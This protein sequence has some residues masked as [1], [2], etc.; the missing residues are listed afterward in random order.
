MDLLIE[1]S[2]LYLT[3]AGADVMHACPAD[4]LNAD[5]L[6]GLSPP[7]VFVIGKIL[8]EAQVTV[9]FFDRL[10]HRKQEQQ[11]AR[12]KV[13][14]GLIV[15]H[16][17]T[18]STMALRRSGCIGSDNQT[19]NQ[20]AIEDNTD[21]SRIEPA[22]ASC[23]FTV[24]SHPARMAVD[25]GNRA[26]LPT[27][28]I[29]VAVSV[30]PRAHCRRTLGENQFRYSRCKKSARLPAYVGSHFLGKR[31]VIRRQSLPDH[32]YFIV[33]FSFDVSHTKPAANSSV[34]N[35]MQR[36]SRLLARKL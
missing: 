35:S 13:S 30:K 25:R 21:K 36:C 4:D 31:L 10:T 9:S 11:L 1:Q 6:Y 3:Q 34:G 22:P 26:A 20:H 23:N 33:R 28:I 7:A 12:P 32:R 5:N 16:F 2:S 14:P 15:G 27:P 8:H 18:P 24:K 29:Q 19:G 17:Q